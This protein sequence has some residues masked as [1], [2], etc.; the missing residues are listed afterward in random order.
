MSEEYHAYVYLNIQGDEPLTRPE[1]IET[2][3]GHEGAVRA[4]KCSRRR[5]REPMWTIR[6]Q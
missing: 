1:H 2:Y 3:H 5:R 4:V 6:A